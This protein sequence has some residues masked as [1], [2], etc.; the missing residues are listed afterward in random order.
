MTSASPNSS[1]NNSTLVAVVDA[2]DELVVCGRNA[3]FVKILKTVDAIA[4]TDS[5]VL[6]MGESGTGKDVVAR[7]IHRKSRRRAGPWV[8]V[9][10][11]AIPHEL[12]E[13]ELF[14]HE[15]GAFTGALSRKDG[16]CVAADGGTLFL[17]E[18]GELPLS[19]QVKL[20]RV[21][22]SGQVRPVGATETVH[23]SFRVVAATNRDL[24]EEVRR[25]RFRLDLFYRLN[26]IGIQLPALRERMDDIP[27]LVEML[28]RRLHERGVCAGSLSG[29]ALATLSQHNWPGNIRELENVVERL[30]ILHPDGDVEPPDVL[31]ELED[32]Q[33][34]TQSPEPQQASGPVG[35]F[36]LDMTLREVEELHIRRVL[37]QFRGNKTRAAE[38]LGIN[39]K[40]LY[41]KMKAAGLERVHFL[42]AAPPE[43]VPPEAVPP[44][45]AAR[46]GAGADPVSEDSARPATLVP[47]SVT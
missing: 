5:T 17:D 34:D 37:W 2:P 13:S 46:A 11:G 45:A 38:A 41:N 4:P 31:R 21:L 42:G 12:V 29:E 10:C 35:S 30:L 39:V 27:E 19:M 6:L 3:A 14:G 32:V 7:L 9:D 1:P 33:L 8:A 23:V 28:S 26:V 36:P 15:K 43:A 40:T 25:G 47:Q 16:L 18:I 22:Q 24:R 44:A 20:L